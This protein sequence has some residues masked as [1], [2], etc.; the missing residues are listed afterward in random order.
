[1]RFNRFGTVLG[2]VGIV[3]ALF[4]GS[5]NADT[6]NQN[7][8][9]D[10]AIFDNA[11]SMSAAQIDAFLNSFPNSCIS[12][13][14]GFQAIDPTGYSVSTGYT[15]GGFVSA[16][17]VIY[18]AA[19]TYGINPQ[20]LLTTLQK[21]QSLVV[22]GASYCNDGD[23]HKYAAAVGYGCPDG[24]TKYYYSNVNLYQRN[25]QMVTTVGPTCVN[26]A[27]KAG[28]SQQ[29]IR[30]AWLLKFGEQRSKGNG[31]WAVIKG[32]WS[33][34][35]DPQTCYG[36]PMTQGTWQRC[37]G[38]ASTYYDGY[39]TIDG[40]A[41]HMDDGAT[42]ALYWYTPHFSGNQ[43]FF[44]IFTGWFGST[45]YKQPIYSKLVVGNQS[46]KVYFISIDNNTRYFVPNWSNLQAFGLDKYQVMPLD[47]SQINTYSDGGTLKTTVWDNNSQRLWLVDGGKKYWF[48]QYCAEWGLDCNNQN[49]GVTFLTSGYFDSLTYGGTSQ[50]LQKFGSV[51]YLMQSGIKKPFANSTSMGAMGYS[52]SQ[53]LT[54][55]E[56][57]S[58]S[59]QPLGSLQ[60]TTPTF[61]QF[62][63]SSGLL[64]FDGQNYH[65]VPSYS[66]YSAWGEIG[67]LS[68]PASSYTT[69]P[70]SSASN[71]SIWVKTT[72][73]KYYLI[74]GDRKVD[75]TAGP[76][77][78]YTG[79]F[80]NVSDQAV[81]YLWTYN[82]HT[83]L[84]I[85]NNGIY[86][87]Q[88]AAKRHVLTNDDYLWLGI[89]SNNIL[90]ITSF[91]ASNIAN[92]PDIIRDGGL[93]T[94]S[95]S[96]N[97]YITNGAASFHIPSSDMFDD[98]GFSWNL[99]HYNL[100]PSILS[101][102][103]SGGDLAR[104]VKPYGGSLSYITNKKQ[105]TINSA[106]ASNWGIDLN[107]AGISN[108]NLAL[109]FNTTSQPLG[110]FVSDKTTGKVYYGS[111]GSYHYIASY[112]TYVSLG[113]LNEPL[114]KVSPDFF[115]NL[116]QGSTLN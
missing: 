29:V 104:W 110:K 84:Y 39:T 27:A 88:N 41:V 4:I 61:I 100:N 46:G 85:P 3:G 98:F 76:S 101:A 23:Q 89:N 63:T 24:G 90:N 40:T 108:T 80:T 9:I 58:N 99:V 34:S 93:F 54:I 113:G 7:K 20:V 30:G 67:I 1:M 2:V 87:I 96:N 72:N 109:L 22:G 65:Y 16:G 82:S 53:I 5:A 50:P 13:G 48:Q 106:A 12:P 77:I 83:N 55:E 18:D 116:T 86:V 94:V 62:N 26:S 28:F 91:T 38:G 81:S 69:A 52:A 19:Q 8:I 74:D 17:Q 14:S 42:A 107:M 73:N 36:G 21:E 68:P 49:G 59:L 112:N 56:G 111:G 115:S 44:S 70:P 35:D 78:W 25:G 60:I 32:N 105:V 37:P 102:Y 45:S 57:D 15:F 71:L 95:N 75:I 11:N 66:I 51:T 114:I 43:H 92:G 64:Y 31:G 79:S 97:L 47:D 10:D 33:N 103:P 6:F